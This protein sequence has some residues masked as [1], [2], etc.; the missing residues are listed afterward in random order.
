M[1]PSYFSIKKADKVLTII[2]EA[3]SVQAVC[4]PSISL[5]KS[6]KWPGSSNLV[7]RS[8]SWQSDGHFLTLLLHTQLA[9]Q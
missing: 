3:L 4:C 7:V 6:L 8:S 9:N 1:S 2:P 5:G